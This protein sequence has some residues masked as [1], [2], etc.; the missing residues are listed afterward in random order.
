[1]S[2]S[3]LGK[4]LNRSLSDGG[5][6]S[7]YLGWGPVVLV[8]QVNGLLCVSAT[9]KKEVTM[10]SGKLSLHPSGPTPPLKNSGAQLGSQ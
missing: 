8:F 9:R 3:I 6:D 7:L 5:E 10:V 4:P 2:L 1:M